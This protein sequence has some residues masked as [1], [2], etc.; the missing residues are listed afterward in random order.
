MPTKRKK[1]PGPPW[2]VILEEIRSQ[3]R[4]TIEAVEVNRET[5]ERRMGDLNGSLT[6]RMDDLERALTARLDGLEEAL[7]RVDEESRARD[8]SLEVAIRDL[9][10]SVK[11]NS[12]DIRELA[13]KLEALTRLEERV[14]ALERRSA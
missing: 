3:N 7:G 2:E 5:L 14:A 8:A 6:T 1:E 10:V 9:K 11:Q 12:V 4:A 13:A